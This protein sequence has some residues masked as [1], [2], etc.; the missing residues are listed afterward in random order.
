MMPSPRP[1]LPTYLRRLPPSDSL[2]WT[3]GFKTQYNIPWY[4][5]INSLFP[6]YY[7]P[8][9]WDKPRC[10]GYC[11]TLS[12]RYLAR[13]QPLLKRTFDNHFKT[14]QDMDQP[15]ELPEPFRSLLYNLGKPPP[16]D[17]PRKLQGQS[18]DEIGEGMPE[19][20]Q[21]NLPEPLL[22]KMTKS[23]FDEALRSTADK[24]IEILSNEDLQTILDE[25]NATLPDDVPRPPHDEAIR[26]LRYTL[27]KQQVD[28]NEGL[29]D[30]CRQI[31]LNQYRKSQ[32]EEF[33]QFLRNG[34][35]T[36]WTSDFPQ[37]LLGM[38]RRLYPEIRD[39]FL[40]LKPMVDEMC[41]VTEQVQAIVTL[42]ND[43]DERF[44]FIYSALEEF[45]NGKDGLR[46]CSQTLDRTIFTNPDEL[47]DAVAIERLSEILTGPVSN[48]MRD[49]ADFTNLKGALCE[50]IDST[51]YELL[52]VFQEDLSLEQAS[53][54]TSLIER[55][56]LLCD[57][58][59]NFKL[60][61][62]PPTTQGDSKSDSDN[63]DEEKFQYSTCLNSAIGEVRV[64]KIIPSIMDGPVEC[65]LVVRN[66]YRD[67]IPEALSYV[68]G[69]RDK[70]TESESVRVDDQAFTPTKN[71][72]KILRDLR[73]PDTIREIWIDAICINQSDNKEKAD[74]VQLMKEIYSRATSTV[75]WLSGGHAVNGKGKSPM[76]EDPVENQ[77]EDQSFNMEGWYAPF[78]ERLG[79][80]EVDQYD[81]AA[82]LK[83]SQKY[84]IDDSWTEKQWVL[85]AML[86]RCAGLVLLY[87]WW[88]R[89]WTI[90]EA[91]CPPN[92]PIFL[93]RG[94]TFTFD[95][96][97]AA[98]N[99]ATKLSSRD[100]HVARQIENR[101]GVMGPEVWQA[102]WRVASSQTG[103]LSRGPFLLHYRRGLEGE[104]HSDVK[105]LTVLLAMAET[106]RATD[107]RDKIFALQS[108][109][110]RCMG[111]LV[112]VD[113][114]EGCG[115]V[116]RRATARHYNASQA[117]PLMKTFKFWFESP[118]NQEESAGPSWV[119]DFT[120]SDAGHR[121][122]KS[123]AETK[124]KVTLDGFISENNLSHL[125]LEADEVDGHFCTPKSLF[126]TGRRIDQICWV[127]EMPTLSDAE[128]LTPFTVLVS[129]SLQVFNVRES[130]LGLPATTEFGGDINTEFLSLNQF[131]MMQNQWPQDP[132]GRDEL[133]NIR[134]QELA[135]KAVF[136]TKKGL[137]GIAT[138]PIKPDD[139]LSWIHGSP[140]YLILREVEDQGK[141]SF[142]TQE[143]RIVARAAINDKLVHNMRDMKALINS[144]PSRRFKII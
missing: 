92:A 69:G 82:I 28:Q 110:P 111:L 130:I 108:L 106:Y 91:G 40:T 59:T 102:V 38:W 124:D 56:E 61:V 136:I 141:G 8:V 119:L 20:L 68:W 46:E 3:R 26:R 47:E 95:D 135:G 128:P 80:V 25:F 7:C 72:Y 79:G 55:F 107:P 13:P 93:F 105:T 57:L 41:I 49:P 12:K 33:R 143:H 76:K 120:Y 125:Q 81:L 17:F 37:A 144:I 74:Q 121:G 24:S 116:F 78:P 137:V 51:I 22:D 132:E 11:M 36:S 118:W 88:E 126:C 85:Y 58:H 9:F 115:A 6:F 77:R 67:D 43:R 29:F 101:Q 123:I 64:L 30:D 84:S 44:S 39:K 15:A 53:I 14:G 34:R 86:L 31:L 2:P 122:S 66:L 142:D 63:K 73:R 87:S 75:I 103:L 98:M 97:T 27:V 134:N 52:N 114:K 5:Y 32:H 62:P 54:G 70:S 140:I 104:R 117:F 96:F 90:Q 19:D 139:F 109:L 42:L 94:Y 16:A 133:A 18:F 71:L 10:P 129:L 112:N 45:A 48:R 60:L 21:P 4:N 1:T 23:I 65:E 127:G 50:I 83:E 100:E 35:H 113:Y 131:F 99:I 89:V 138:V